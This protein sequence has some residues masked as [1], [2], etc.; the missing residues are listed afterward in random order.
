MSIP[1]SYCRWLAGFFFVDGMDRH[2]IYQEAVLAAW[3]APAGL[4]H[5][6]ARRRI[7][8]L[9]R[10]SQRGGRPTFCELVD[11]PDWIDD[12]AYVTVPGFSP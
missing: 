5:V 6:A 3:L 2:D 1:E 8:E 4:E 12:P 10:R 9:L 11:S 7:I